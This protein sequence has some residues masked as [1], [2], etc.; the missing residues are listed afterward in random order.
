MD[1]LQGVVWAFWWPL[2][3]PQKTGH[4]PTKID[5]SRT[6]TA[7]DSIKPAIGLHSTT[8]ELESFV[9]DEQE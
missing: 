8:S 2:E 9:L 4:L 3:T 5:K 7:G 1:G 6:H